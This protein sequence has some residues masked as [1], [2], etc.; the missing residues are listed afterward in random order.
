M[1]KSD[2]VSCQRQGACGLITLNRQSALNALTL[3]MVREIARAL[4]IWQSDDRV[5]RVVIQSSGG[6]AF[7][8]GGDIRLLYEEGRAGR[9]DGQMQFWGEEYALNLTIR[10]YPKPYVALVDG[11]VMGGGVGVS[12]HGSHVVAGDHFSF[13]MPEVGIGF[14]PDVGATWFLP[15]LRGAAG[16]RLALTGGRVKADE[17]VLLGLAHSRVTSAQLS[18]LL[19]DLVAG[20]A[21]D[22][23]IAQYQSIPMETMPDAAEVAFGAPTLAD[24]VAS[25]TQMAGQGN[26]AAAGNLKLLHQKSPTSLV[27]AEH[28]MRIGGG[29]SMAQ[30]MQIEWNIVSH[31][32]REHDFYEGVR[33]LTIDKDQN[34]KWQPAR[35]EDVDRAYVLSWFEAAYGGQVWLQGGKASVS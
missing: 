4:E 31:I 7:S 26:A 22:T 9:H 5:T 1:S 6:K 28:Q 30:A 23:A 34:P 18:A 10:N 16:M 32:C 25:L 27:V 14:F 20:Q 19:A 3:P 33:A 8:A 13:A 11:I 35:I 29:L 21:V 15:R 2:D 17:A 24:I 12:L